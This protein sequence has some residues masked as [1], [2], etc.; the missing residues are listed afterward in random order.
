MSYRIRKIDKQAREQS[1]ERKMY[2]IAEERKAEL[3]S[4]R[5]REILT[6]ENRENERQQRNTEK[7]W[8]QNLGLLGH[9]RINISV[10]DKNKH[11]GLT[12][13]ERKKEER[14]IIYSNTAKEKKIYRATE[15]ER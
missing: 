7:H 12:E 8:R 3:H 10:S 13:R 11:G 5:E 6:K 14:E 9:R 1:L 4:S 15:R 2:I